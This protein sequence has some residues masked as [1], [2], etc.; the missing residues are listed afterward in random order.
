MPTWARTKKITYQYLRRLDNPIVVI[1]A[2]ISGVVNPA[3]LSDFSVPIKNVIMEGASIQLLTNGV[4]E[5][6]V[7]NGKMV[8]CL[9]IQN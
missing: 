3:H 7:F 5:E 6:K 2:D 9:R 8:G 1:H 4:V